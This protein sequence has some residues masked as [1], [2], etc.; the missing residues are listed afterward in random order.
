M[1][2]ERFWDIFERV[3]WMQKH[4]VIGKV[5]AEVGA[6][7]LSVSGL[8]G[9][10]TEQL[11]STR[12]DV[13]R[14][15]DFRVP[16]A[17]RA[18]PHCQGMIEKEVDRCDHCGK[19]V[20]IVKPNPWSR[21]F[22]PPRSEGQEPD[23]WSRTGNVMAGPRPQQQKAEIDALLRHPSGLHIEIGSPVVHTP[24]GQSGRLVH[25]HD[26]RSVLRDPSGAVSEVP[27]DEIDAFPM[28]GPV[29][30]PGGEHGGYGGAPASQPRPDLGGPRPFPPK[31]ARPGRAGDL[32]SREGLLTL[33]RTIQRDYTPHFCRAAVYVGPGRMRKGGSPTLERGR[34]VRN[35]QGQ[36]GR[37]LGSSLLQAAVQ[38][39]DGE[40]TSVVLEKLAELEAV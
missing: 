23:A 20:P 27:F 28:V 9:R 4:P 29:A 5:A 24:T 13:R 35:G 26:G 6:H 40:T 25:V 2:K 15:L 34:R 33:A 11:L 7:H 37:V 3:Y 31:G 38:Y 17:K 22:N 8:S 32:A 14:E 36:V 39:D 10:L 18:C 30:P 21:K 12:P 16:P 1:T 19:Y